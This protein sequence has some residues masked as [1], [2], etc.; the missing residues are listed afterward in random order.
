MRRHPV[1]PDYGNIHAGARGEPAGEWSMNGDHPMI[2][3]NSIVSRALKR[4]LNAN[5]FLS[6][7]ALGACVDSAEPFLKN[8]EPIL[9][10]K[11]RVHVVPVGKEQTDPGGEILAYAWNGVRYVRNPSQAGH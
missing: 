4:I 6:M 7:L 11:L 8:A 1:H 3:C 10:Q 5:A 9:G 2:A